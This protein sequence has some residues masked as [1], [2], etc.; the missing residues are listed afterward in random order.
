MWREGSEGKEEE[1]EGREERRGRD[2][3]THRLYRG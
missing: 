3:P 1:K 2:I